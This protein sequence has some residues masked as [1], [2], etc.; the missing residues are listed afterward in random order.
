MCRLVL[1]SSYAPGDGIVTSEEAVALTKHG[2]SEDV[3]MA[4]FVLLCADKDGRPN[5]LF[6][7][8]HWNVP[9]E[10][11]LHDLRRIVDPWATYQP[12]AVSQRAAASSVADLIPGAN[13]ERAAE[14]IRACLRAHGG[15]P[16]GKSRSPPAQ[17]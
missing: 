17:K 3:C 9:I 2:A 15:P 13:L 16:L 8:V 14:L 12:L 1:P 4:V 7:Q 6:R 5:V 10:V 11:L